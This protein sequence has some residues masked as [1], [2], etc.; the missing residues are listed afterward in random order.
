VIYSKHSVGT[1]GVP[2]LSFKEHEVGDSHFRNLRNFI[3]R[4]FAVWGDRNVRSIDYGEIEDFILGQTSI[5]SKTRKEMNSS[6]R[7]LWEWLRKRRILQRYEIPD[8]P[9]VD[10]ELGWRNRVTKTI[11]YEILAEIYKISS[12]INLR[13]WIAIKWLT[14]YIAI[15]PNE[16]LSPFTGAHDIQVPRH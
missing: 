7:S 15:R 8:F 1:S 6:L 9:V 16:M 14:T 10:A 5:G 13:S 12:H 2:A 11:Q 3:N 4:G